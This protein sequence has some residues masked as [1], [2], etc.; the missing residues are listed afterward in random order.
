MDRRNG[1]GNGCL[2]RGRGG[3]RIRCGSGCGSVR[4]RTQAWQALGGD[5]GGALGLRCGVFA[6]SEILLRLR[7]KI[8]LRSGDDENLFE[9]GEVCRRLDADARVRLM[10]RIGLDGL[11]GADFEA[12]REDLVAA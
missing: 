10:V 2:R 1:L 8:A 4:I 6:G 7:G 3:C 9:L 12:A 11:D 5:F